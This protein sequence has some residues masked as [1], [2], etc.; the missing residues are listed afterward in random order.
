[1]LCAAV[2]LE[3][4]HFRKQRGCLLKMRAPIFRTDFGAWR[5]WR[6]FL[7]GVGPIPY[8]CI[9][10]VGIV[11]K[12][13]T[14]CCVPFLSHVWKWDER[15]REREREREGDRM[16]W[17]K[18]WREDVFGSTCVPPLTLGCICIG[19]ISLWN[20]YSFE[21]DSNIFNLKRWKMSQIWYSFTLISN[22]F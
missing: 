12:V 22:I 9:V 8:L 19:C 3:K 20:I 15:E 7:C 2:R 17:E 18:T 21:Y 13:W 10:D 5:L 16:R 11:I 1:M 6:H 14:H 4:D